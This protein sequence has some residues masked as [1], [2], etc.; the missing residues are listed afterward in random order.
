[1]TIIDE[2]YL[3]LMNFH[4]L[5]NI[6]N[7]T[8]AQSIEKALLDDPKR[9]GM[10]PDFILGVNNPLMIIGQCLAQAKTQNYKIDQQ[11]YDDLI[12]IAPTIDIQNDEDESLIAMSH[13]GLLNHE[14][15]ELFV[16]HK[17]EITEKITNDVEGEPKS[18]IEGI[19][20]DLKS[21]SQLSP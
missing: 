21:R 19:F 12:S 15:L 20:D 18:F 6:K 8:A 3:S 7:I 14:N 13:F 11:T 17:D 5:K 2:K 4:D 9:K 10:D 16:L 1:M